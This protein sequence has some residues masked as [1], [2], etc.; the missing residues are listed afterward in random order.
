MRQAFEEAFAR[1]S[2]RISVTAVVDAIDR[3]DISAVLSMLELTDADLSP[4]REALIETYGT[5]GNIAA[6]TFPKSA[7]MGAFY[8]NTGHPRAQAWANGHV[9]NLIE[10]IRLDTLAMAREVVEGGISEGLSGA[11]VARSITG[12]KVGNRRVGGFLGLN[13][14]QAGSIKRSRA[15]LLSGDPDLMAQYLDLK[16]RDRR[17]D[18]RV[19]DAIAAGKPLKGKALT[20]VLEAHRNKAL[21]YRGKVI[22]RNE[23]RNALH[24][25][26]REGMAQVLE[27]DDVETVTKKWLHGLSREPRPDHVAANGTVIDISEKF[28]IGGVLMEHPHDQT[29]P[30]EHTINCNCNVFYRVKFKVM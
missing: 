26:N 8:F 25:G 15:L 22:A 30:A 17:F 28:D 18:K 20:E 19:R 3:R 11:T 23:T 14:Q 4:L 29:A 7:P 12:A 1:L 10:G 27:R 9:G 5:G 21:G 16:L 13:S 24:A 6:A 2:G